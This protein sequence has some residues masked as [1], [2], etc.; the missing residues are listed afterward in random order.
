[1]STPLFCPPAPSSR[2]GPSAGD[3]SSVSGPSSRSDASAS[4][5]TS[6]TTIESEEMR[7]PSLLNE[8]APSV[9]SSTFYQPRERVSHPPPSTGPSSA[10]GH[11]FDAPP[12][13]NFF[14]QSRHQQDEFDQEHLSTSEV[15]YSTSVGVIQ[16]ALQAL[17]AVYDDFPNADQASS[18][19]AD[20]VTNAFNSYRAPYPPQNALR[21]DWVVFSTLCQSLR[22]PVFPIQPDKV[23]LVLSAHV[24]TLPISLPLRQL[25]Q[26]AIP[27]APS[28]VERTMIC[29]QVA[30]NATRHLWP[31]V[32]CFIRGAEAYDPTNILLEAVRPASVPPQPIS[33]SGFHAPAPRASLTKPREET[34]VLVKGV[35]SRP[36]ITNVPAAPLTKATDKAPMTPR[37]PP[38]LEESSLAALCEDLP[39]LLKEMQAE[40]GDP[41]IF[42]VAG[43]RFS[44]TANSPAFAERVESLFNT[45]TIYTH[46][47]AVLSFPTYPITTLKLAIFALSMTP[48]PLGQKVDQVAPILKE[49][50]EV[51]RATG[52]QLEGLLKDAT[53]LRM[54]TRGGD[55]QIPDEEKSEWVRW[56]EEVMRD[57]KGPD[58]V[59][60]GKKRPSQPGKKRIKRSLSP[61]DSEASNSSNTRARSTPTESS[62]GKGARQ[63]RSRLHPTVKTEP[64]S[65]SSSRAG[66]PSASSTGTGAPREKKGKNPWHGF[67]APVQPVDYPRWVPEKVGTLPEDR[68]EPVLP[69]ILACPWW[70]PKKKKAPKKPHPEEEKVDQGP[71]TLTLA[72]GAGAGPTEEDEE[73]AEEEKKRQEQMQRSIALHRPKRG[74]LDMRPFDVSSLWS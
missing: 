30:A 44:E 37:V 70:V 38:P 14:A 54:I 59:T 41:T 51:P 35:T 72:G 7:I 17:R 36:H 31:D 67:Y 39:V 15:L 18:G 33:T 20:A 8:P 28:V 9:R 55:R 58:P 66:T 68:R 32:R 69:P 56:Q 53:V 2:T 11:A 34:P 62:R 48:G 1:M 6:Q 22:V 64:S 46:I 29:L 49:R 27:P 61:T 47:T 65:R 45:A 63:P 3:S 43:A 4:A 25:A 12:Q 57:W 23:A 16:S 13:A 60:K 50:R 71:L 19:S 5:S 74:G 21:S 42:D 40:V 52:T 10:N 26:F 73:D 24:P